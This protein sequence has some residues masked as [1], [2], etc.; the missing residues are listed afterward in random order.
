MQHSSYFIRVYVW[1]YTL[2]IYVCPVV[3]YLHESN[4]QKIKKATLDCEVLKNFRP[5]SNLPFLSKLIEKVIAERLVSHMQDNGML[6]NFNLL[7]NLIIVQRLHCSKFNKNDMLI[8]IDQGGGATLV[9][10]DLSSAFDTIDHAVLFDLWQDTFGISGTALS[11]LKSYLH[12]RMQC[13]Q[14][15]GIISGYAKL[16]CGVPQGSVLGPLNFCFICM[17]WHGN[18]LF[19]IVHNIIENILTKHKNI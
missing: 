19:D 2:L 13:V 5:I 1:V 14:I 15:E 6:Q 17:V 11:L 4:Q 7:I 12:G 18:I 16:V 8:S 10:L 3:L 9:L